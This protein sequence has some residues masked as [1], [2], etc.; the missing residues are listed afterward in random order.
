MTTASNPNLSIF[1]TLLSL[2]TGR[3]CS[4]VET[5]TGTSY[6]A[7]D[8]LSQLEARVRIYEKRKKMYNKTDAAIDILNNLADL[9][10][11]DAAK[12]KFVQINGAPTLT[13]LKLEV[14]ERVQKLSERFLEQYK[15]LVEENNLAA[16]GG[17]MAIDIRVQQGLAPRV[18][19]SPFSIEDGKL[20]TA[21]AKYETSQGAYKEIDDLMT[22][23]K[24]FN[25]ELATLKRISPASVDDIL[26]KFNFNPWD[27]TRTGQPALNQLKLA[28]TAREQLVQGYIAAFNAYLPTDAGE[29]QKKLDTFVNPNKAAGD[30][31]GLNWPVGKSG[32]DYIHGYSEN[33]LQSQ[34]LQLR[35]NIA[36]QAAQLGGLTAAKVAYRNEFG[37]DPKVEGQITGLTSAADVQN[38]QAKR[39]KIIAELTKYSKLSSVFS[40]QSD[41]DLQLKLDTAKNIFIAYYREY[42]DQPSIVFQQSSDLNNIMAL[43]NQRQALNQRAAAIMSTVLV[44][45]LT[46]DVGDD[47][48]KYE[49]AI[50]QREKAVKAFKEIG[51]ESNN[52]T[53]MDLSD[54]ELKTEYDA[55]KL[56][57]DRVKASYK[58]QRDV[59]DDMIKKKNSKVEL[60]L[61][62]RETLL[63]DI[64]A[65]NL[66][67]DGDS[68]SKGDQVL[69]DLIQKN[70]DRYNELVSEIT[71]ATG[72]PFA[73]NAPTNTPPL[74]DLE[75]QF[76][77]LSDARQLLLQD[78]D[79]ILA[80]S[81][82]LVIKGKALREVVSELKTMSNS[83]I[84]AKLKEIEAIAKG[85]SQANM[86]GARV[87]AIE[88]SIA[89]L[90]QLIESLDMSDLQQAKKT[91][92]GYRRALDNYLT[93]LDKEDGDI[94]TDTSLSPVKKAELKGDVARVRQMIGRE[95]VKVGVKDQEIKQEE[96][97]A[98][99]T[100][101]RAAQVQQYI[102]EIQDQDAQSSNLVDDFNVTYETKTEYAIEMLQDLLNAEMSR[103]KNLDAEKAQ[104]SN[105]FVI[106]LD[107][108]RKGKDLFDPGEEVSIL[109]QS[110]S[111][112]D[113]PDGGVITGQSSNS[114]KTMF[115]K[116]VKMR[117]KSI[118]LT[119][120]AQAPL[121]S[122]ELGW[123]EVDKTDRL[124]I[125]SW[126]RVVPNRD[127]DQSKEVLK[128][129]GLEWL[130]EPLYVDMLDRK[131]VF[132]YNGF[133]REYQQLLKDDNTED[134]TK[135]AEYTD[136]QGVPI[137]CSILLPSNTSLG[138][139]FGVPVDLVTVGV[140]GTEPIEYLAAPSIGGLLTEV[141]ERLI[142]A[143]VSPKTRSFPNRDERNDI[144]DILKAFFIPDDGGGVK[145]TPNSDPIDITDDATF[146]DFEAW[147]KVLK[148]EADGTSSGIRFL[149]PGSPAKLAYDSGFIEQA[150]TE[151]AFG[152]LQEE[153]LNVAKVKLRIHRVQPYENMKSVGAEK[154]KGT[155]YL[156]LQCA[157][158]NNYCV[159]IKD[160]RSPV[161]D[162]LDISRRLYIF[163]K[164]GKGLEDH[165]K[166]MSVEAA[167]ASTTPVAS[168]LLDTDDE[169]V[170]NF[171]FIPNI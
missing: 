168:T 27:I 49:A 158:K 21:L 149:I 153:L 24:V 41:D 142:E 92:M 85:T 82:G 65:R 45:L 31:V 129:M 131:R 112:F 163:N 64:G 154:K 115:Y 70:D 52:P 161:F 156:C 114:Q 75:T 140:A 66:N 57:I 145:A 54:A 108:L 99:N 10:K 167:M 17:I 33:Q 97:K 126:A 110:L 61:N 171:R 132:N 9:I 32:M 136:A 2:N 18:D 3:G 127:T 13:A 23:F 111:N 34:T 5:N 148:A 89:G 150:C 102:A 6:L 59:L 166:M 12:D 68:I 124:F 101:A 77:Q 134:Y 117:S 164:D 25:E 60:D 94:E 100:Q 86:M 113:T 11:N 62:A 8:E 116:S 144:N 36:V 95:K 128:T 72:T 141:R 53:Y 29:K 88:A 69:E 122:I 80:T 44:D 98:A 76:K 83:D 107:E 160:N 79:T 159:L 138:G 120:S 43:T 137:R 133:L 14:E 96:S 151:A 4:V 50:V 169:D 55:R 130:T 16:Q 106:K 56:I 71:L 139:I 48:A 28:V 81:S 170:S 51:G 15:I 47:N 155:P 19:A 20:N 90:G 78:A 103:L 67:P 121:K 135:R 58:N 143:G 125:S 46:T 26:A 84:E 105:D 147:K 40:D 35:N 37:S 93:E 30:T 146:G 42:K 74:R 63:Q 22:I 118:N 1:K 91:A 73:G 87:S 7:G 104:E 162:F 157:N 109:I 123:E 165:N 152:F 38:A 39:A 119:G